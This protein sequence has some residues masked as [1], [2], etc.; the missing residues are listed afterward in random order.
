MPRPYKGTS[1]QRTMQQK[2]AQ[3]RHQPSNRDQ[4]AQRCLKIKSTESQ[5][6]LHSDTQKSTANPLQLQNNGPGNITLQQPQDPTSTDLPS[7]NILEL[8]LCAAFH[9][10]KV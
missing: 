1:F 6:T 3:P 9:S 7:F 5:H 10:M 8:D 4:E 2:Y